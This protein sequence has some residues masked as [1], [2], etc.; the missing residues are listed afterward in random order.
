MSAAPTDRFTH[1]LVVAY[2]ADLDRALS[3]AEPRER[4]DTLAAVADHIGE[5]LGQDV[6]PTDQQVRMVLADLGPVERIAAVATPAAGR[7]VPE[8]ERWVGVAVLLTAVAALVIAIIVPW[9]SAALA[10]AGIVVA[11]V[12]LRRRAGRLTE[13]RAAAVINAVTLVVVAVL[14]L[15]LLSTG[16]GAPTVDPAQ[17]V[18]GRA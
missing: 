18:T 11:E 13:L 16:S 10:V 8:L 3:G 12:L 14:G 7:P 5:A 6:P 2:L 4:A 15:T 9:L 17:P 1:P